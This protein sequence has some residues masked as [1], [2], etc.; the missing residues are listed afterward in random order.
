M[1]VAII[2]GGVVGCA[3]LRE[4]SMNSFN[5]VLLE[6]SPVL[7]TGASG[8][9]SGIVHTGFDTKPGTLESS[10]VKRG[11]TLLTKYLEEHSHDVPAKNVGAFMV[12]WNQNDLRALDEVKQKADKNNVRVYT[13]TPQQL[14]KAEP[15]LA[16]GCVGCLVIP[17]ETV[18]DPWKLPMAYVRDAIQTGRA[19]VKTDWEVTSAEWDGVE[20]KWTLHSKKQNKPLHCRCVVNCGGLWGDKVAQLLADATQT[21]QQ[22]QQQGTSRVAE[23]PTTPSDSGFCIRP[24]R[25]DFLVYKQE[26]INA[27]VGVSNN[28][29]DGKLLSHI[30]LPVPTAH[31][32][33]VLVYPSVYGDVVV[34]PTAVDQHNKQLPQPQPAQDVIEALE[35]VVHQK[36]PCLKDAQY[37]FT[38]TGLRPAIPQAT[39]YHVVSDRSCCCV[40]VAGIRSTGVTASMGM[41]ECCADVHVYPHPTQHLLNMYT[42][43][44]NSFGW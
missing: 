38:Y 35:R 16:R 41:C 34:G 21:Q 11:F 8:G 23:H 32:K 6:K 17:G 7:L 37:S 15:N 1:D 30:V 31:T 36:L 20:K 18:V 33:G 28:G 29:G 4:L 43:W 13:I 39:D 9:N 14:Y 24:R 26:H 42:H 10:C 2:G 22:Q 27:T 19:T 40:T 25:G 5:C 12:A 3:L 44:L